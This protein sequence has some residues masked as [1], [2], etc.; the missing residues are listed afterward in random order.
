MDNWWTQTMSEQP[1]VDCGT[2]VSA[3]DSGLMDNGFDFVEKNVLCTE[4][5]VTTS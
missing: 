5:S 2:I 4:V 1:L 3:C